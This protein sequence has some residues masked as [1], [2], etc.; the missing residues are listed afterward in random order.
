MVEDGFVAVLGSG[1]GDQQGGRKGAVTGGQGERPGQPYAGDFAVVGDLLFPVGEG[2]ERILRPGEAGHFLNP[3]Q[4]Q[5]QDDS[6]LA[7]LPVDRPAVRIDAALEDQ[8]GDPHL[9][10]Q[11]VVGQ[12]EF[13]HPQGLATLVQDDHEGTEAAVRPRFELDEYAQ[14]GAV[15]HSQG[16]V[17]DT[18]QVCFFGGEDS[19]PGSQCQQGSTDYKLSHQGISG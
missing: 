4:D 18:L 16:P 15:G 13:I 8:A 17:P 9:Q 1:T 11:D 10:M 2:P 12:G 7:D 14:F 3:L 5:G 6:R 19:G